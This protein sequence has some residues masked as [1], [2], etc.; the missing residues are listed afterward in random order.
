MTVDNPNEFL[1]RT[2]IRH[3][4]GRLIGCF[5]PG[6]IAVK[7][8][9]LKWSELPMEMRR[10]LTNYGLTDK[11]AATDWPTPAEKEE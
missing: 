3:F 11:L 4:Y 2:G 1:D 9:Y 7:N 8:R 6:D 5:V 10:Q